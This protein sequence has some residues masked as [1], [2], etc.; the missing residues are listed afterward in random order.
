MNMSHANQGWKKA[1][2]SGNYYFRSI[3]VD[4][5]CVVPSAALR[6]DKPKPGGSTAKPGKSARLGLVI[7]QRSGEI[8]TN[9]VCFWSPNA[10]WYPADPVDL[11]KGPLL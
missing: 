9:P 4:L 5:S 1:G 8:C 6:D 7:S 3:E 10:A 11:P 2:Y